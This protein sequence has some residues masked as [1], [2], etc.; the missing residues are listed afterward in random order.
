MSVGTLVVLNGAASAGKTTMAEALLPLL[1]P[2]CA[3]ETYDLVLDP[4]TLTPR[5]CAL[6]ITRCLE[7]GPAPSAFRRLAP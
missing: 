2:M 3:H 7:G 5:E 1:G 4:S 6:A